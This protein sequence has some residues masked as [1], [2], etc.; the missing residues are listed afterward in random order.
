MVSNFK[1][2]SLVILLLVNLLVVILIGAVFITAENNPLTEAYWK[3]SGSI[4]IG[5]TC[6]LLAAVALY[7]LTIIKQ[8]TI[9]KD[10]ILFK[11]Q[12]FPFLKK[13]RLFSYYDY[14][15]T[16]EEETETESFEALWLIKNGK[17]EDHISSMFYSNYNELKEAITI[18][19]A[20]KLEMSAVKQWL[21][22]MGM[23]L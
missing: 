12:L 5:I 15:K 4:I 1:R 11:N 3:E 23:R 8:I 10:S 7:S 13:E 14:T 18:K 6:I 21:Y 2:G 16:V 19:Q 22:R 17:L 9:K 20:G